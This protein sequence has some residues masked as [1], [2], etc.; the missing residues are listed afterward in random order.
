MSTDQLG[1]DRLSAHRASSRVAQLWQRLRSEGLLSGEPPQQQ[2]SAPWYLGLMLGVAAWFA[3]VLA[4]LAC[5]LTWSLS[6]GDEFAVLAVLWISPG[7]MLLRMQN[8]GVFAHQLGLALLIA[9]EIAAA[10]ALATW[11][12]EP[13]PTLLAGGVLCAVLAVLAARPAARVLNVLAACACW[14]LFLRWSLTGEPWAWR[15]AAT[16]ALAP[17]L[18]TWALAWLPML[19]ALGLLVRSEAQW[20]GRAQAPFLRAVLLGLMLALAFA[21]PLSDPLAGLLGVQESDGRRNWLALWPLLSLFAAGA[22]A[23]V[24][25]VALQQRMRVMVAV[26]LF[27]LLLHLANF[28]YALGVSLLAKSLLMVVM[29][30]GLLIAAHL[31][32]KRLQVNGA[33]A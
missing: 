9:G 15:E 22:A 25:A 27:G 31:Q 23:A 28:Y 13:Q 5:V 20:M 32:S 19:A 11:L 4:M 3:G 29:G 7:L 2:P 21:T 14:V 26:C 12:D 24:A 1:T 18:L 33:G 16:P 8:F 10:V 6:G 17:T 30:A